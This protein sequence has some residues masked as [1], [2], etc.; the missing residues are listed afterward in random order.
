MKLRKVKNFNNLKAIYITA[1]LTPMEQQKNKLFRVEQKNKEGNFKRDY[2]AEENIESS[3]FLCTD[4]YDSQ[5]TNCS[6]S[7][8]FT[9][10]PVNSEQTI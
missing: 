3:S 4:N 5:D 7:L 10:N 8:S 2:S 9:T 6:S 1:D